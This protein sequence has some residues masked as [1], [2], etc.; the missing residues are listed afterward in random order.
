MN[1]QTMIDALRRYGGK[2][3]ALG[4]ADDLW[5]RLDFLHKTA[6][7]RPLH[8]GRDAGSREGIT[9]DAVYKLVREYSG[10]LGSRS[11]RIRCE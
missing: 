7:F 1:K 11:E 3:C 10:A 6:L 2:Q 9:P 5:R 8:H 4:E